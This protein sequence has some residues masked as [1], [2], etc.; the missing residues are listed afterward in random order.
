MTRSR[1]CSFVRDHFKWKFPS[2]NGVDHPHP[3]HPLHHFHHK[4]T[5]HF[6]DLDLCLARLRHRWSCPLTPFIDLQK[7]RF[8]P[9]HATPFIDHL[10]GGMQRQSSCGSKVPQSI[11]GV[12]LPPFE[13]IYSL[14]VRSTILLFKTHSY[15]STFDGLYPNEPNTDFKMFCIIGGPQITA[16]ASSA[17]GKC[18]C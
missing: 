2:R 7:E 4:S 5:D 9:P 8:R 6:G 10:G 3:S 17:G 15:T 14:L 12:D 18:P 13:S 16:S 1:T 11:H